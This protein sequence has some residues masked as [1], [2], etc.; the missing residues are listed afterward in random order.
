M[1]TKKEVVYTMD[2]ETKKQKRKIDDKKYKLYQK[3]GEVNVYP[4]GLHEVRIIATNK[5]KKVKP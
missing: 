1:K 2:C 3:Y 5:I 4:N